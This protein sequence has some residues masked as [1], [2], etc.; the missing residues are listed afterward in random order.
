MRRL[1]WVLLFGLINSLCY[2]QANIEITEKR[3][4]FND[5]GNYFFDR[6][7][8]KKAIV[9]YNMAFEK[10]ATDYFS[11]LKKADAYTKLKLFPQAEECYRIVLENNQLVVLDNS[12]RLKYAFVLLANNKTEEFKKWLDLYSQNEKKIKIY[13]DSTIVIVENADETK[14]SANLKVYRGKMPDGSKVTIDGFSNRIEQPSFNSQKTLLF[15]VSDAPGGKGGMDIYSSRFV[16][17]KWTLPENMGDAINTSGDEL[18]PFILNDSILYFTST[19]HKGYG[20]KDIYRVNLNDAAKTV[21]NLGDKINTASDDYCM[22]VLPD[23]QTGYFSSNRNGKENIYKVGIFNFKMK[24]M[25]YQPKKKPSL[26]DS[27]LNLILSGGEEYDISP[28]GNNSYEFSFQPKE[29]YKIVLQKENILVEDILNNK[30]LTPEQKKDLLLN[31]PPVQKAEVKLKKGLKYQFASGQ[32]T[33][34]SAYKNALKEKARKYQTPSGNTINLTVLAKELQLTPGEVYSI[35]FVKDNTKVS[36]ISNLIINGRTIGI[37]GQSFFIVMPLKTEVNF[38]IQT[39]IDDL[40]KSFSSQKYALVVDEGQVFNEKEDA[41]KWLISLTVNTDSLQ[42]VKPDNRFSAKEIGIIPGTEYILTLSKPDL[43]T[44]ENVEIIVPLTRGVKYNLSSSTSDEDYKEELS[45]FLTGREGVEPANE[46]VID[47]SV[48][49]K[50]LE[51]QPGENV[52]FHLL[53]AKKIPKKPVTEEIKSSITIDGRVIEITGDEKYTINVPF[54]IKRKVNLQTDINYLQDNFK[55]DAFTMKLDTISFNSEIAV[56]TTGYGKLKTT[57]Y[58]S[59]SVNTTS[60]DEIEKQDQFVASEVSIITGK[61][62]ILTVSKLNKETNETDEI[63]VPIIKQ[64]KYDFTSNPNSEEEYKKSI[65]EF[66][67]GRKDIKTVDGTVIDITLLSK[68]LQIKEGDEITFSLLPVKKLSKTPTP[69]EII[70]SSLYLDKKMVEFTSI[71]KYSINIPLNKNNLV[72][73]QT[74]IEY[75]Q[76][77][78]EPS[79]FSVNVDTFEFF[80]EIT[81][82]TA[83]YGYMVEKDPVF[84]MVTVNFNL[85]E[86]AL[87]PET[88][89][90]I[91]EKVVDALKGD[92]RLY[93]TIKGYTDALGDPTYNFNLSKKRAESVKEFLKTNGVG[94]SRIK[95]MSFG[96]SQLLSKNKKWKEMTESELRKYR[97]VEIV[98][99]LPK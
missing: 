40:D 38:N 26:E 9:Y 76:N 57:G 35:R 44:G 62:Y 75:L 67:A 10:D 86:F 70:K 80:S 21:V 42:N 30:G 65:E 23:G 59:M 25:A 11:V 72:N 73:M 31:P 71:Q 48:L 69:E 58:L 78:F 14:E 97:K 3:N 81:V 46:E 18:Y 96:A 92:N 64:V 99:Y 84:D 5:K 20:G 17:N 7:D 28:T 29:D 74:N 52:S 55:A 16:N 54:N 89:K 49:S 60:F 37:Y 12:Y 94:D 45:Q 87:N 27:Q 88:K 98:I 8:Y 41:S 90:I 36:E 63:I 68:E 51:V 34:S 61:D 79:S 82:D 56:D 66:M 2:S 47:I 22:F 83:G 85:N 24:Y 43:K 39:D 19:A 91:E 1:I 53:P 15:F 95:T 33:I 6:N 50:E 77:N 32:N 13:K 4:V 93:V